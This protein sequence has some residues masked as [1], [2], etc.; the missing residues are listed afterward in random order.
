MSIVKMVSYCLRIGLTFYGPVITSLSQNKKSYGEPR[1]SLSIL[2]KN[3]QENYYIPFSSSVFFE[4][5]LVVSRVVPTGSLGKLGQSLMPSQNI[6]VLISEIIHDLP[7]LDLSL[8][9]VQEAF[10]AV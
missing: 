6:L 5:C 8:T 9:P 4:F 10:H 2:Q 3:N 1:K 7:V